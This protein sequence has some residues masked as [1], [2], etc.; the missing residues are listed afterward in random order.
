MILLLYISSL[1]FEAWSDAFRSKGKKWHWQKAGIFAPLLVVPM[2]YSDW[3]LV[4]VYVLLRVAVFD[5]L[6]NAFAGN[7]LDYK[8]DDW[9]GRILKKFNPPLAAE[10]FGRAVILFGA[11]MIAI[12]Q[13]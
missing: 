5:I 7:Y 4:L 3:L 10:L 11:I 1:I 2:F 12:Q 13:L 9:W 8:G 6:F